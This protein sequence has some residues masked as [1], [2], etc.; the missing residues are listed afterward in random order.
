MEVITSADG[1]DDF[2]LAVLT[3]MNDQTSR[4]VMFHFDTDFIDCIREKWRLF[5]W[6]QF[7]TK[8]NI[9]L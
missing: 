5:D 9:F 3:H 1:G 6:L 8:I 7:N 4:V 2:N